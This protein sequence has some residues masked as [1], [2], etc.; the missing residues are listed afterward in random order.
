MRTP[1]AL[2]VAAMFVSFAPA[3]AQDVPTVDVTVGEKPYTL[4]VKSYEIGIA[5]L[6]EVHTTNDG[7]FPDA[8]VWVQ[9]PDGWVQVVPCDNLR[10]TCTRIPL[11]QID[12]AY[13]GM[14]L[15]FEEWAGPG[16]APSIE[17]EE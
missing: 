4:P 1:I 17:E 7:V 8:L 13:Q 2:L 14:S 6:D 9:T 12:G 3:A 15:V 5:Y 10:I 16:S 11:V